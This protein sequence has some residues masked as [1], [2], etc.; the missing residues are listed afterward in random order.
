ML[1]DR[2]AHTII[3]TTDP[4]AARS[5][6][7]GTLGFVPLRAIEG[8]VMYAAGDGSLFALS[9]SSGRASGTH[10]QMAFT[11]PDIEADVAELRSRGLV[12]KDYDLPTL[13]TVNG[14]A[15][16]GP[17]RAAWFA[18]PEGNLIGLVEFGEGG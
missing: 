7:E 14:I 6:Y 10:T 11:T 1:S 4:E 13:T 9:R 15:P 3:P 5:F 2:R 17:N 8:A 12:F 16:L 18:D